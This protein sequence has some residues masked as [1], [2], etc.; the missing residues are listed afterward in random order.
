MWSGH[1]ERVPYSPIGKYMPTNIDTQIHKSICI[2]YVHALL[3]I[4]MKNKQEGRESLRLFFSK[5]SGKA[6]EDVVGD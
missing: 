6:K 5:G 3:P 1:T 4:H 2:R